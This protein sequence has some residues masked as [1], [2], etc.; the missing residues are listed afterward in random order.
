MVTR[1]RPKREK[2]RCSTI[3][4]TLRVACSTG[5]VIKRSTSGAPRLGEEVMTST[6][7]FVISGTASMGNRVT[8]YAPQ[9]MS[10]RTNMPMMSLFLTEKLMI[11]FNMR[12]QY[13]ERDQIDQ[14]VHWQSLGR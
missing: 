4:G 8:E 7:L 9:P 2:L 12:I 3:P 6:W 5:T 1:L 13:Y 11:A 14:R 10:E